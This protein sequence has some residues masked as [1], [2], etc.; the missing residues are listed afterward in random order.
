MTRPFRTMIVL[1]I[2]ASAGGNAGAIAQSHRPTATWSVVDHREIEVDGKPMALSPDGRWLAGPGPEE[3]FC[4]WDVETLDPTCDGRRIPL[5]IPRSIVWAPDSTAV[6]FSTDALTLFIDSDVLVFEIETGTLVNLTDDDPG[7]EDFAPLK[8]DREETEPVP[9][10]LFPAWSPD[11]DELVFARTEWGAGS[12]S[13]ALMTIDRAGG[14]PA[15]LRDLR[16]RMPFL[17]YTPMRWLDDGS[18]L[19]SILNVDAEDRSNGI[20]HLTADGDPELLVPGAAEDDIP[21]PLIADVSPAEDIISVVSFGRNAEPLGYYPRF[22][23]VDL[24]SG[25]AT[26]VEDL[27]G[28]VASPQDPGA[29][30]SPYLSGPARFSPDG[31]AM[32]TWSRRGD[33]ADLLIVDADGNVEALGI[34]AMLGEETATSRRVI[35]MGIDWAANETVFV[36]LAGGTSEGDGVDGLLVMLEAGD[37]TVDTTPVV[38]CGCTPPPRD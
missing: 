13:T 22:F 29:G 19:F 4:V 30:N 28:T 20:W 21:I 12:M 1:L 36:G 38:P 2:L 15:K 10:D 37:R 8:L 5:I 27:T 26:S 34:G 25:E 3:D 7:D 24:A 14:E 31:K 6:A 33:D 9:V 35:E 18:I 11:S 17:V 32:I 16:P 23:L